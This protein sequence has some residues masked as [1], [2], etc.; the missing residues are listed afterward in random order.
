MSRLY[1]LYKREV[2]A[3]FTYL[4]TYVIIGGFL[5]IVGLLYYLAFSWFL[6]M[7]RHAPQYAALSREL[8][9][10]STV[11]GTTFRAMGV[12]SLFAL[13]LLTMPLWAGERRQGTLEL[14]L[15]FPLRN[16]DIV[17][18][19]FLAGLTVYAVLLLLTLLYPFL[20]AASGPLALGP[21]LAGYV[22]A[23][24]LGAAL[25]ALGLLCFTWTANQTVACILAWAMVLGLWLIGQAA[26]FVGGKLGILLV[27][28]SL[29]N[30][31]GNFVK[32]RIETQD[33]AYF[34]LFTLSCLFLTWYGVAA[35]RRQG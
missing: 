16:T 32:G 14:L 35:T 2:Q 13:P 15:S 17:L 24:L 18:G 11:I 1:A 8:D 23:L 7:H 21:I 5:A 29:A 20:T 34:G 12:V 9:L 6:A 25:L 19:K 27:H 26:N 10:G 30:H 22:G 4:P 28:L 33:M 3:Y 31:Y